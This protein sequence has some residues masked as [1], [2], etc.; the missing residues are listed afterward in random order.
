[1]DVKLLVKLL[2]KDILFLTK[3]PTVLLTS[4]LAVDSLVIFMVREK[5]I[6]LPHFKEKALSILHL[7]SVELKSLNGYL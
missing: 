3:C 5:V 7:I 1:M 4:G 6:S 2:T